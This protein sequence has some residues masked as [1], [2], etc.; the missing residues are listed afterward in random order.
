MDNIA[1]IKLDLSDQALRADYSKK[2]Q[3]ME[4]DFQYPLGSSCFMIRHGSDPY[5]YFSYFEQLGQPYFYVLQ[6]AANVIGSICCVLRE[7]KGQKVWYIC[8]LKIKP[9]AQFKGMPKLMYQWL[10]ENILAIT[11]AFYF[12]N[13]SPEKHNGLYKIVQRLM[14]NYPLQISPYYIYELTQKTIKEGAVIAHNHGKKDIIMN[15]QSLNLYH[16]MNHANERC[17]HVQYV[18]KAQI[19]ED[20]VIMLGSTGLMDHHEPSSEGI[21]VSCNFTMLNDLSTFEI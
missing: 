18:A 17:D 2:L 21:F 16:V 9:S 1:V 3:K 10:H 11:D 4:M 19:E 5:D 6:S 14:S 13:M 20:A 8:D 7:I 15:H 12:V